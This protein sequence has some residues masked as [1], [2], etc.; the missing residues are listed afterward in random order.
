MKAILKFL[1]FAFL[2]HGFGDFGVSA[3]T[4]SYD[5]T[6]SRIP[7]QPC[8]G[9]PQFPCSSSP[10]R[11][12]LTFPQPSPSDC[13]N[14]LRGLGGID[15]VLEGVEE[16]PQYCETKAEATDNNII[17]RC[18]EI[19]PLDSPECR[20]CVVKERCKGD[21]SPCEL[22]QGCYN[23]C[24]KACAQA[25]PQEVKYSC[26]CDGPKQCPLGF[27]DKCPENVECATS[28]LISVSLVSSCVITT[29]ATKCSP[30]L[31]VQDGEGVFTSS[32]EE[33]EKKCKSLADLCAACK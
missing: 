9:P 3:D 18:A 6:P 28:E 2:V 4:L 1:V 24:Q 26:N 13:S 8:S 14:T 19:Q 22:S 17:A 16:Q 15:A 7:G 25:P 30:V 5:N 27:P 23:I 33:F 20:N 21:G 11:P 12:T 32:F 31:K 10:D 29:S